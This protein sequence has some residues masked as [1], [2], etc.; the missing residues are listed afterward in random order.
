M[1]VRVCVYVCA[2]AG[3]GS[4]WST[5]KGE[6]GRKPVGVTPHCLENSHPGGGMSHQPVGRCSLGWG[7]EWD[8]CCS[9]LRL[10]SLL[11]HSAP[12]YR[13][14]GKGAYK[15]GKHRQRAN[16]VSSRAKVTGFKSWLLLLKI[17]VYFLSS[18]PGLWG[19]DAEISLR[20]LLW[21]LLLIESSKVV[22]MVING[23]YGY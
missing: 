5:E 14:S 11:T 13:D 23:S 20:G 19:G 4:V 17:N 1:G 8:S 18:F 9:P 22:V 7:Q 15:N 16:I 6:R 21:W 3:A 12:T 2:R 10:S